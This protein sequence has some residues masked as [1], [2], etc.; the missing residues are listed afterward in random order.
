MRAIIV[1][2]DDYVKVASKTFS[3]VIFTLRSLEI[4]CKKAESSFS[5]VIRLSVYVR[6]DL[7]IKLSLQRPLQNFLE[8]GSNISNIINN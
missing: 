3:H 4:A 6:L 2:T 5:R 7:I 8:V 1:C